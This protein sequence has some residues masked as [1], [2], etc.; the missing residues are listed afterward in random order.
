M[1]RVARGPTW[2]WL[3]VVAII[4]TAMLGKI[5]YDRQ[6]LLHHGREITLQVI[7][8]DPRDLFR[9]DYVT[10][11]YALTPIKPATLDAATDVAGLTKGDVVYVTIRQSVDE[12]WQVRSLAPRY[13]TT[14]ADGDVVMKARIQNRFGIAGSADDAIDVRFGIERYFVPEGTGTALEAKVRDNTIKSIIAVGR[15]GS[16]GIKGLVIGGQRHE[17]PPLF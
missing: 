9:G 13:P 7:P 1:M 11:G 6:T 12:S 15:D 3:A 14:T 16:V 2:L 5:V 17:D 4:Q 8:V 10:L